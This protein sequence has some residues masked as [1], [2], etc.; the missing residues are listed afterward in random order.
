MNL[1][2]TCGKS[3]PTNVLNKTLFFKRTCT[4][5]SYKSVAQSNMIK[6]LA[7]RTTAGH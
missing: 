7:L 1:H 4:S 2:V 6:D 5:R 3:K